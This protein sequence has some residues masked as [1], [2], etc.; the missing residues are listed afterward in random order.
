MCS[1]G[2]KAVWFYLPTALKT[3]NPK[4]WVKRILDRLFPQKTFLLFQDSYLD[5]LLPNSYQYSSKKNSLWFTPAISAFLV[6]VVGTMDI[7]VQYTD[8]NTSELFGQIKRQWLPAS[9]TVVSDC[10]FHWKILAPDNTCLK[11]ERWTVQVKKNLKN[12]SLK[13]VSQILHYLKLRNAH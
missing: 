4:K 10:L 2:Q 7:F 6:M 11:K 13:H 8:G 3:T 5:E 9:L 1:W 12:I